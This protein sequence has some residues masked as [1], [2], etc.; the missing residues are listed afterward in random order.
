MSD[1]NQQALTL[2]GRSFR[3]VLFDLDGT[4]YGQPLLR[5]LMAL[6]LLLLPIRVRSLTKA[7]RVWRAISL[8]RKIREQI[9]HQ[10]TPDSSLDVIEYQ[11]PA[12]ALGM[13]VD[14]LKSIIE[15]WIYAR[16]LKYL[17]Y[18]KRRGVD[19]LLSFLSSK[20]ISLGVYSD[21]PAEEK[22]KSLGLASYF[23]LALAATDTEINAFKP[24]TAGFLHAC[25]RWDIAPDEVLYIGDRPELDAEGANASGMTSAIIGSKG[26]KL[27]GDKNGYLSIQSFKELVT[28]LQLQSR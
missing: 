9:R 12:E 3:A 23:N 20:D 10:Q 16:P 28:L 5:G 8:F 25:K 2:N 7:K 4:L 26:S 24:D 21:Y 11:W 6:E 1:I 19:E 13:P 15:E 18:A 17:R 27:D 14:E 22:I